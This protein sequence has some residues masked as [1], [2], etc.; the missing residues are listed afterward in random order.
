M[1]VTYKTYLLPCVIL[2]EGA[3]STQLAMGPRNIQDFRVHTLQRCKRTWHL[4]IQELEFQLRFSTNVVR[5]TF[6]FTFKSCSFSCNFQ[7]CTFTFDNGV[8]LN[9]CKFHA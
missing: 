4:H 2:S 7:R 6:T 5:C 3:E 8:N 9:F 1:Y